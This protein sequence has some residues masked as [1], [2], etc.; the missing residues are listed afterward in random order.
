VSATGP[1]GRS[2]RMS[3]L[4]GSLITAG[5]HDDLV[6]FRQHRFDMGATRT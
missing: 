2:G 5:I 1:P 4:S 3:L 6:P